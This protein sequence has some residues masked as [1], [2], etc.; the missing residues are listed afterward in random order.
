[1]IN[2]DKILVMD[3]GSLVEFDHPYYLLKNENGYLRNLV[4]QT[5]ASLLEEAEKSYNLKNIKID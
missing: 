3:G 2:A 5:S 1:V 4:N